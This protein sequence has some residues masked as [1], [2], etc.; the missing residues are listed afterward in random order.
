[1]TA[2]RVPSA[3]PSTARTRREISATRRS[4]A[5]ASSRASAERGAH[6][7]EKDPAGRLSIGCSRQRLG[8]RGHRLELSPPD[9]DELFGLTGA[10]TAR[11]HLAAVAAAEQ[12][13]ECRQQ[14]DDAR[15]E[16]DPNVT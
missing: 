6:F 1:M 2:I 15:R 11:E 5:R 12:E 4:R 13:D 9:R 8:D 16:Q 14:R 3:S 7:I 10:G